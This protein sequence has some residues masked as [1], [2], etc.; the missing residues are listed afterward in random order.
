[1]VFVFPLILGN[2]THSS[3]LHY[4]NPYQPNHYEIAISS[5]GEVIQDYDFDKLFPVLGFGAKLPPDGRVSHEF[6][7][8]RFTFVAR[9]PS[10]SYS[11]CSEIN[12]SSLFENRA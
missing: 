8:V 7:V 11:L 1:M 10:W 3:S 12:S 4:I 5:V 9:Q 6:S 2:P